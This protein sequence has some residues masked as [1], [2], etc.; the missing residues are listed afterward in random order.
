MGKMIDGPTRDYFIKGGGWAFSG[1]LV[2]SFVTFLM[3]TILARVLFPDDMGQYFLAINLATFFSLFARLGLENTLLRFISGALGKTQLARVREI[4]YK[5]LLL[6]AL[7]SVLVFLLV[8]IL[9][10]WIA[11]YLFNTG[12]FATI[13]DYVA[14][15]LVVLTFQVLLGSIFRA[16][17]DIRAF[18]I[19]DG[20]IPDL[21]TVIF[22][23]FYWLSSEHVS[24]ERILL[25]MIAAGL[26]NVILAFLAINLKLKS[27]P[28]SSQT[29]E[30]YHDLF[31]Y[32]WPLF[33][34]ALATF[35]MSQSDV[36]IIAAFRARE[37]V[38]I[39]G[40]ATRL[41]LLTSFSLS[42]ANVVVSPLIARLYSQGAKEQLERILRSTATLIAVPAI[43]VLLIFIFLGGPILTVVFGNYYRSGVVVLAVLSMGQ[44]ANVLSGSCGYLL[45]LTGYQ[46]LV[47]RIN[48]ISIAIFWAIG[49]VFVGSQG[50]IGV[51]IALMIAILYQQ[52]NY[53]YFAKKHTGINTL[54]YINLHMVVQN[55]KSR[56]M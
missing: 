16:L 35:F 24:P 36:W 11:H 7:S 40:V 13:V 12:K 42:V 28:E 1:K 38:A 43:I 9:K 5:G 22:L 29:K 3:S 2:S 52:L 21:I 54:P 55:I 6:A 32:T 41:V 14:I 26:L 51:A 53:L 46:Y 56:W 19:F 47:F 18:V 34:N 20:F 23:L 37:D 44:L 48:I 45:I 50:A 39:Y 17:Q 15:L 30:I 10:F 33:L 49:I 8:Q 31:I 27:L 25:I 4:I